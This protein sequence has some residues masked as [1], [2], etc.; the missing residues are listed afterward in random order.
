MICAPAEIALPASR[1]RR[2]VPEA[3]DVFA[4]LN[5]DP[6][7]MEFFRIH[8]PLRKAKPRSSEYRKGSASEVLESMP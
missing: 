6:I 5:A 3:I 8:G 4:A 1:L 7:V 2:F